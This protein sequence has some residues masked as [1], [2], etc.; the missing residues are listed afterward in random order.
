MQTRRFKSLGL[1]RRRSDAVQVRVK[2][3]ASIIVRMS[4]SVWF[5]V[6]FSYLNHGVGSIHANR[7]NTQNF[8]IVCESMAT[9]AQGVHALAKLLAHRLDA[10][11]ALEDGPQLVRIACAAL[12]SKVST[13]AE[14]STVTPIPTPVSLG[15]QWRSSCSGSGSSSSETFTGWENQARITDDGRLELTISFI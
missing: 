2:S 7:A 1:H 6:L 11:L 12:A 9:T 14:I 15:H 13:D 5:C 10:F 3:Y 4:L 8:K